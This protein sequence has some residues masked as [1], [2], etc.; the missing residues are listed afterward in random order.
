M[1]QTIALMIGVIQNFNRKKLS[2]RHLF[3]DP[4][5]I[6]EAVDLVDS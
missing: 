6:H 3:L 4:R 1:H 5:L 2:S